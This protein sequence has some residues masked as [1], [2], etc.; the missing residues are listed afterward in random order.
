MKEYGAMTLVYTQF[1]LYT[2]HLYSVRV[3]CKHWIV[4]MT[5]YETTGFSVTN[6]KF[7]SHTFCKYELKI[8]SFANCKN[9]GSMKIL[10]G[11]QLTI[12]YLRKSQITRNESQ[13]E[14][15]TS[16]FVCR[17]FFFFACTLQYETNCQRCSQ[18]R[19]IE[20]TVYHISKCVCFCVFFVDINNHIP[21]EHRM[22]AY[23]MLVLLYTQVGIQ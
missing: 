6:H 5:H 10:S 3:H 11:N 2:V 9:R 8:E 20:Y 23:K 13:K 7:R 19:A 1:T 4:T 17:F 21:Y 18:K 15:R 12:I 22:N 16:R 14:F